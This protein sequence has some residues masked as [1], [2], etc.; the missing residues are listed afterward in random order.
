[1][2]KKIILSVMLAI[3]MIASAHMTP[4]DSLQEVSVNNAYLQRLTPAETKDF[5]KL[6][7]FSQHWFLGVQGGAS[8]FI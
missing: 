5:V 7:K 2:I 3:P 8:A 1:M 4:V 6:G